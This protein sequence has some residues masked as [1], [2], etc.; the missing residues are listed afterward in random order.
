MLNMR[1]RLI[2]L[3]NAGFLIGGLN[4]LLER[5]VPY[6]F[7]FLKL[8]TELKKGC[9]VLIRKHPFGDALASSSDPCGTL[10]DLGPRL[11]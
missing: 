4:S 1:L 6:S 11:P 3:R 7:P 8:S 10:D 9:S 2:K 5:T